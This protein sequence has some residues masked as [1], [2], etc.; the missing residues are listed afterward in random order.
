MVLRLAAHRL[1]AYWRGW[2]VLALLVGVAG[3]GTLAAAAGARR[4]E[5]AYPRFLTWSR[6]SDMLV[7][8]AGRG[9]SGFDDAL[10]RLPHAAAVAPIV[11]LNL[12]PVNARGQ[13]AG[14]IVV[15]A[16]LD[17][18]YGTLVDRSRVLAGRF[19]LAGRPHEVAI[20]Q[21]GA[22]ELHVHVGSY[23]RLAALPNTPGPVAGGQDHLRTLRV[24][25]VGILVTRA[26]IDPVTD[27][28]KVPHIVASIGLWH[29]LGPRYEAFDG[30]E[31]RLQAGTA[32]ATFGRE[33]EALARQFPGTHG[34]IYQ[35][36]ESTQ[37]ATIER[38]I[39][40]AAVALW[41]F[42][43]V[44][45]LTALL[46]VGQAASRV[47]ASA[48]TDN[49]ALAALGATRSQ[50]TAAGLINVAAA[51]V[52]G[53]VLAVLLAVAVSPLM[54]IGVARLA[55][56]DPGLSVDATV[57]GIGAPVIV[58]ML[59][60]RAAW[61]ARRFAAARLVAAADAAP[62][63]RSR[64]ADGLAGI[65]LPV[66]VSTGVRLALEPG[67][68]RTAVPVRAVLAG[69]TLSV[70][71]VTGA[72]TFGA[73]LVHL[74]QAPRLYGRAWDAAIDLQF[75]AI[76]TAKIAALFAADTQIAGWSFGDHGVISIGH[77]VVPAIG[78]ARG[79]GPML[80]PTLLQGRP[81]RTASEIVLGHHHAATI[82]QAGRRVGDRSHRRP[83][84]ALSH[85]RARRLPQLWPG[86]LYPD[87]PRPGR[88]DHRRRARIAG[89][90]R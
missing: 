47:L 40:P 23:L 21:H 55:E 19:P 52:L 41:L 51:G 53:A 29:E 57:L 75:G 12:E 31:V 44:L 49:Q 89:Q 11:G 56:P 9:T 32:A 15:A 66:T 87:R 45:A 13:L 69:T 1:T 77:V 81:P 62:L 83:P 36:D 8:P 48:S 64:L 3:A 78:L 90:F 34:Q 38:S 24:R 82:R 72:F 54:P 85:R 60:A 22:A 26:S 4:T 39:E 61:P 2:L 70:L 18:R 58:V 50:L 79:S 37:A 46:V 63:R 10:A 35:A 84:A 88:R 73:N 5:S 33:A 71:A 25:V 42:A 6:A 17:R 80:S 59:L 86:Q 7:A 28:D 43:I 30:A 27:L 14:D 65:G 67:R 20:D 16:P 76:T 74:V 68:G